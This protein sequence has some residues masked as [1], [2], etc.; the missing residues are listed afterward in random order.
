M[1][2]QPISLN[3]PPKPSQSGTWSCRSTVMS[4]VAGDRRQRPGL[5]V[6]ARRGRER[7][8]A[9]RRRP[10]GA[11]RGAARPGGA[12]AA[13]RAR[14]SGAAGGAGAARGARGSGGPGRSGDAGRGA[15]PVRSPR[16]RPASC[17]DRPAVPPWPVVPASPLA[18]A[19]PR[20]SRLAG[21]RRSRVA[22][23][24]A[25]RVRLAGSAR[26][27][28]ENERGT[29]RPDGEKARQ[30]LH[31]PIFPPTGLPLTVSTPGGRG[32]EPPRKARAAK[33]APRPREYHHVP[34]MRTHKT[35]VLAVFGV[36]RWASCCGCRRSRGRCCP[37]TRRSTPRPPM[38]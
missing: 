12:A 16:S 13:A 17:S 4:A 32:S 29:S 26:R 35:A 25:R 28:R 30:S 20:G 15:A 1:S 6:R 14:G 36:S 27:A 34:G 19:W 31:R 7:E 11:G 21:P 23:S 22:G 10:A 8:R 9:R 18:P 3:A 38:R 5:P 37:T 24:R 2:S 33:A